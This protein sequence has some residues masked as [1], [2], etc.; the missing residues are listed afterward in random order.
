MT[1][2]EQ[3]VLLAKSD[4]T[5]LERLLK[6]YLPFLKKVV[7]QI[8]NTSLEYDDMLSIAMLA[9]VNAIRQY[10]LQRGTFLSFLQLAVK[11][12][13]LDEC[14]KAKRSWS[15]QTLSDSVEEDFDSSIQEY[16]KEEET[17][18]L[19]VEIEQL[20]ETL[21]GYDIDFFELQSCA[22]KQVRSRKQCIDLAILLT[23]DDCLMG[24]LYKN[25]RLPQK[26]LAKKGSVSI[27]TIEKYRKYLIA[28]A[29]ILTGDYTA[30]RTFLPYKGGAD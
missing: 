9:F 25:H 13:I 26:E 15:F 1:E 18:C 16:L 17:R 28:A 27:K 3:R 10:D 12:R 23:K 8:Q 29:I 24:L 22:P 7:L 19:R 30:I 2:L 11:S 14:R 21:Q 4:R 5:E 6:D 20:E